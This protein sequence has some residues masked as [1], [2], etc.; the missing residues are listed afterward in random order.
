MINRNH[1]NKDYIGKIR[2]GKY[3]EK[4]LNKK[5]L[6]DLKMKKYQFV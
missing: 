3:T 6:Q 5:V 2:Y 1:V 4:N